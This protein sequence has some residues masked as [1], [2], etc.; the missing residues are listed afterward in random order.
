MVGPLTVSSREAN[1][2]MRERIVSEPSEGERRVALI[3]SCRHGQHQLSSPD[4]LFVDILESQYAF[5][6]F[7]SIL[8][9]PQ[10]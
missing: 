6:L 3:A 7:G 1:R 10:R 5:D 8:H 4:G 9:S 2:E